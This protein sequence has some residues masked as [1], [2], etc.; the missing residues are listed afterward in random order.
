MRPPSAARYL[1]YRTERPFATGL[2]HQRA[3]LVCVL[4]EVHALARLAVLPP[5]CLDPVHNFGVDRPWNCTTYV[6]LGRSRML[7][8]A[9]DEHPLPLA[10]CPPPDTVAIA[11]S[12]G[13]PV[14]SEATDVP[15]FVRRLEPGV[16][17]RVV[18]AAVPRMRFRCYASALVLA[19]AAPVV[20]VLRDRAARD[21][22][23]AHLRRGARLPPPLG[24]PAGPARIARHLRGRGVED[25][26]A[27][28]FLSDERRAAFWKP[29]ESRYDVVRH[30]G[31]PPPAALVANTGGGPDNYLL[32][33]VEK[34]I[35]R[36]AAVRVETFPESADVTRAFVLLSPRAVRLANRA[37]PA[38]NALRRARAPHPTPHGHRT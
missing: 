29:L 18:P 10:G 26:A 5:L 37:G 21:F 14:P 20:A 11:P 12:G 4:R 19:L 32:Y 13:A 6:D 36:Q 33:E 3:N 24:R 27:L 23:T 30:I 28:F 17:R 1:A 15:L 31:F 25:G 35:V 2:N 16:F 34:E 7:D 38:L 9:G 22:A 8:P